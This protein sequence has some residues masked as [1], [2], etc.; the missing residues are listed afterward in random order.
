VPHPHTKV[1]GF[2]HRHIDIIQSGGS[3]LNIVRCIDYLSGGMASVILA[4]NR[5][6]AYDLKHALI[7]LRISELRQEIMEDSNPCR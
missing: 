5:L 3:P 6:T 2:R 7:C 4:Q 1:C